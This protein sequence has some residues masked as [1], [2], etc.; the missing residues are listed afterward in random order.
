MELP[1][2]KLSG[3]SEESALFPLSL[4]PSLS[5]LKIY[6]SFLTFII[7][8]LILNSSHMIMSCFQFSFQMEENFSSQSLISLPC[9]KV[10]YFLATKFLMYCDGWRVITADETGTKPQE[11]DVST[12]LEKNGEILL[13]CSLKE[14]AVW[15]VSPMQSWRV[16]P[17]LPSSRYGSLR[18]AH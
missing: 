11:R 3:T 13:G 1:P 12:A 10:K 15:R 4:L 9:P 14:G 18:V 5:P 16:L 8:V 6:N 7:H 2:L 17:P